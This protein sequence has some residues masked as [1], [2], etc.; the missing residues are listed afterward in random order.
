MHYPPASCLAEDDR[1][2]GPLAGIRV[3]AVEHSVAGPLCTRILGD[4]GA[5]VLKIERSGTDGDF[6]RHWDSHAAGEGA[7]FW[8]LNRRK[9]SL[10]LDLSA[11]GDRELLSDLLAQADVL[12]HNMSPA[13]ATRAA[14]DKESVA[15]AWPTLIACQ[16]S[17]YGADTPSVSHR[18]AY[19]ML[20]QAESGIMSLT[21]TPDDVCRVG[22]SIC[23]VSTGLYAALLILAALRD[24]D[25]SGTGARIDLAMFDV[26]LEF[27][28]PMLTSHLN[29]GVEYE[30][31]SA[32]HHA[33]APYGVFTC[34]DGNQIVLAIEQDAEWRAFCREVLG[35]ELLADDDRFATNG[36]RIANRSEVDA[37]VERHLA[38]TDID[39]FV[40]T[41]DR[42][43]FA[44]GRVNDI[45][46]V[47]GHPLVTGRAVVEDVESAS[48]EIVRSL[49]GLPERVFGA[50]AGE[51][52]RPPKF[53]EDRTETMTLGTL[54]GD[55]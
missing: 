21:G 38:Q 34:G 50:P 8:W 51:R 52:I 1:A 23:D 19:D 35:D 32:R 10:A 39:A 27:V 11:P 41:C 25:R 9:Q 43:G 12:V 2:G 18:K 16:I 28:G 44:Y 33:I 49:V 54:G 7:Q 45:A 17:G 13:A 6:A 48:G 53:D 42:H 14:L 31:S 37:L 15:R 55:T 29:A 24:R 4:L 20:I 3:V 30:R 40:A 46:A 47:S 36:R 5:H 22:V 26:A